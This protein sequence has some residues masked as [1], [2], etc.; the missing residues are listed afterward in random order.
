M[1]KSVPKD[2][3]QH[4]PVEPVKTAMSATERKRLQ[5]ERDRERGHVEITVKVPLERVDEL[6]DIAA[7]MRKRKK[8]S[9]AGKPKKNDDRQ[10]DWVDHAN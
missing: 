9:D 4:S 8:R 7:S 1:S 5:R 3:V 10:L 6:R 2:D